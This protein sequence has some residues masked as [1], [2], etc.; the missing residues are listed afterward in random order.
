M[1]TI[2]LINSQEYCKELYKEMEWPGRHPEFVSAIEC[3]IADLSDMPHIEA[4]PIIRATWKK[5]IQKGSYWYACS[6][7]EEDVPKN[8][9]G[10]DYFSNRCPKCGA[11]MS[12]PEIDLEG[13]E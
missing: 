11:H 3:A 7:C 10:S 13:N 2:Y 4:E 5:I 6:N 12:G 1:S 8:R 9:W